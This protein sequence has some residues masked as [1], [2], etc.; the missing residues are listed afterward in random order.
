MFKQRRAKKTRPSAGGGGQRNLS[1]LTFVVLVVLVL[2]GAV[3]AANFFF[4]RKKSAFE[5][6][7]GAKHHRRHNPSASPS[8]PSSLALTAPG[9]RRGGRHSRAPA[10]EVPLDDLFEHQVHAD[11]IMELFQQAQ[12]G[13]PKKMVLSDE[14]A[15]LLGKRLSNHVRENEVQA[16]RD[17]MAGGAGASG[18]NDG[19]GPGAEVDSE[20]HVEDKLMSLLAQME[21]EAAAVHNSGSAAKQKAHEKDLRQ[22]KEKFLEILKE[23]K[24][25]DPRKHKMKPEELKA[26]AEL[27]VEENKQNNGGTTTAMPREALRAAAAKSAAAKVKKGS[28]EINIPIPQSKGGD[29]CFVCDRPQ[30]VRAPECRAFV[31]TIDAMDQSIL[32]DTSVIFTFC[33]EPFESLYHSI[34]SVLETAPRHLLKEIVLVDDGSELDW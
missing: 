12:H 22:K 25:F 17:V 33:N 18:G 5:P 11:D 2:C 10:A 32:P 3:F 30:D 29:K 13:L 7:A 8:S 23:R 21:H 27:V 24:N 34:H 9:H 28:P 20:S 19:K 16:H 26:M 15:F 6:P 14:E 31:D 4:L 1:P